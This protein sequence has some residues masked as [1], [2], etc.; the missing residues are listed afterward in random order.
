M[1]PEQL[2][3]KALDNAL[4]VFDI[5]ENVKKYTQRECVT[6]AISTA[7]DVL[8][9]GIGFTKPDLLQPVIVDRSKLEEAARIYF[10]KMF[11]RA[12]TERDLFQG[13]GEFLDALD[14]L[15]Q[16]GVIKPAQE[17]QQPE[18]PTLRD[19]YAAAALTGIYASGIDRGLSG[20]GEIANTALFQAD[21]MLAARKAEGSK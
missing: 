14:A 9:E 15:L 6:A 17:E 18:Q 8:S 13:K 4:G 10:E 3:Q 20:V 19:F 1:T 16:A 7:L 12:P 5:Y 21:A 11:G 2:R